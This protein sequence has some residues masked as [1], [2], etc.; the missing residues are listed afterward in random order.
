[1]AKQCKRWRDPLQVD[2]PNLVPMPK[3]Y[4]PTPYSV[5][6]YDDPEFMR[7]DYLNPPKNP[8]KKENDRLQVFILVAGRIAIKVFFKIVSFSMKTIIHGYRFLKGLKS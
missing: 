2:N 8:K 5:P 3:D 4:V 7:N 6:L 1:M